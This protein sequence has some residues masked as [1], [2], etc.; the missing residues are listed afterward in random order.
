MT[1]VPRPNLVAVAS[2]LLGALALLVHSCSCVGGVAFTLPVSALCSVLGLGLGLVARRQSA[3]TGH[4]ADNAWWGI[5]IGGTVAGAN[6]LAIAAGAAV[7]LASASE[8]P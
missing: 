8:S 6:A 2:V 5:A 4:G 7:F 1:D 3:V